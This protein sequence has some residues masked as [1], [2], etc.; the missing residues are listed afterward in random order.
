M[1]PLL[2][3]RNLADLRGCHRLLLAYLGTQVS[4]KVGLLYSYHLIHFSVSLSLLSRFNGCNSVATLLTQFRVY[5]LDH[6]P[7]AAI[8][9][10]HFPSARPSAPVLLL[11]DLSAPTRPA[12]PHQKDKM[13]QS[14]NPEQSH[15]KTRIISV[16]AGTAI[17]LSCGTNYAFSAWEPQFAKRLGLSATEANLIGNFGNIG[18]YAMGIPGGILIDSRGPRW[19][20]FVGVVGLAVGY[21]PLHRAYDQGEK[22]MS[23]T[24]LCFFSLMTGIASCTAFSAALKVCATNWPQHRGTA[25]AFPLSAFG[26]SAFFWTTLSAFLF[27][28]DTS[29]YLLLL[30]VG[31]TFLVFVGMFFLRTVPPNT[32]YEAVP[33]DE[34]PGS[35]RRESS[36][37]RRLSQHSR[38][39]SK[40]ST[41]GEIG[42]LPTLS[43]NLCFANLIAQVQ[44]QSDH[45]L[46]PPIPTTQVTSK[47]PNLMLTT[48]VNQTSLA[49]YFSNNS[50]FGNSG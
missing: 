29:G 3:F 31:A 2:W 41:G 45:P 20:V 44:Q 48:R 35:V 5:V 28:D 33:T 19:G 42:K 6:L 37:M 49:G 50:S 10:E 23:L 14:T 32:A 22:S 25:T 7:L 40:A 47:T 8:S 26:L 13:H 24:A 30:A 1:L 15:R 16:I 9:C 11:D 34:R 39:S 4:L 12:T 43:L 36:R 17:A 38:H 46:S 18:M 27:P 21:F